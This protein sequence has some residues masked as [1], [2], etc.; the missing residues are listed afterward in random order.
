MIG[1]TE[2]LEGLAKS[3]AFWQCIFDLQASVPIQSG[4]RLWATFPVSI[5]IQTFLIIRCGP[6]LKPPIS[7]VCQKYS[8]IQKKKKNIHV[9]IRCNVWILFRVKYPYKRWIPTAQFSARLVYRPCPFHRSPPPYHN[10][11]ITLS[12]CLP[13]YTIRTL[14]HQLTISV[15]ELRMTSSTV[16]AKS[17]SPNRVDW[18][19]YI[20]MI[21]EHQ[22]T[23]FSDTQACAY[24]QA[25]MKNGGLMTGEKGHVR[26]QRGYRGSGPP[27]RIT[28]YMGFYRN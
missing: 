21:T 1:K 10:T 5:S 27:W 19:I 17:I 4:Y 25:S 24:A 28:S 6:N 14:N 26:I 12:M 23:L 15:R 7:T 18:F 3:I 22:F 9:C 11:T 8:P 2:E 20:E 13:V 16:I